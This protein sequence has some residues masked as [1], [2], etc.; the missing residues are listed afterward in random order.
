M[1]EL[2]DDAEIL[3]FLKRDPI[4]HLYSIGDLDDFFRPHARYFGFPAQ[5]ELE[6]V[7][8]LY[9]PGGGHH[10]LLAYGGKAAHLREL[11]A[12]LPSRFYAHASP[13]LLGELSGE[14]HG[15]F[16]KMGLSELKGTLSSREIRPLSE[17]DLNSLLA[18]YSQNYPG[19]WFDPRM[20]STGQ[21]VGGFEKGAL[22]A[23][24]G[25]H[26]Y[27]PKFRVAA[28]GNIAVA[29]AAR[30]KGWARE[31]TH[32]LCALFRGIDHVAL[33]VKA[34]N[35]AAIRAYESIG[36]VKHAEYEE[37][38]VTRPAFVPN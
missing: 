13:H 28:L 8:L 22:V 29:E 6:S 26:V 27:S 1:R 15:R 21:Y 31:V 38:S 9:S 23:V 11:S 35:T 19:N 14:S 18:F 12:R 3:A 2:R 17:L 33:N 5:G 10:V 4:L 32:F 25:I 37:W 34:N 24:A 16:W 30:G 20:L 36:F 7:F